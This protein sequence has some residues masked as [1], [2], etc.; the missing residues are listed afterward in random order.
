MLGVTWLMIAA[1]SPT[2][3]PRRLR[4]ADTRTLRVS[5]A[6]TNLNFG[7]RAFGVAGSQL[8]WNS[9]SPTVRQPDIPYSWFSAYKPLFSATSCVMPL[10]RCCVTDR[11]GKRPML[12]SK[13][14]PTDFDLHPYSHTQLWFAVYDIHP[15]VCVC[16]CVR[17]M[18]TIL[19]QMQSEQRYGDMRRD[20]VWLWL[21]SRRRYTIQHGLLFILLILEGR[22]AE[23]AQ[24][25]DP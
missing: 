24:L 5:W 6:R 7:A 18:S 13:P 23:L 16:V 14:A 17:S 22:K 12:Q 8:W 25:V 20:S 3:R 10:Q 4:S 9:L 19:Q 15:C 11:A 2:H 21:R 1:L